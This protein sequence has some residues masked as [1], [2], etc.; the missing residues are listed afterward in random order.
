MNSTG[1]QIKEMTRKTG[2]KAGTIRFYEKLG[3]LEPVERRP[4]QYRSFNEH[5]IY[6]VR[7]CSLV[8]GG[9]VNTRL[10]RIS[11]DIIA[12]AKDW[13]LEAFDRATQNYLKAIDQDIVR[14]KKAISLVARPIDQE[15]NDGREY[16]KRE[17][18]KIEYS[19]KEAAELLGVTPETIR[20]WERNRLLAQKPVYSRRAYQPAEIRRMHIIRLLLDTGYSCMAI[21]RFL[22]EYDAGQNQKAAGFLTGTLEDK[23][24]KSRTDQYMKSLMRAR[25]QAD[26]LRCFLDDMKSL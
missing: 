26:A 2:V 3:F 14:T 5:H 11:M 12:A 16:L 13:N 21:L 19:K 20:N 9:F 23:E 8:F 18:L 25:E 10:R 4:N 15:E 1:Y 24:L 7:I 6:Q 17:Y 22:T